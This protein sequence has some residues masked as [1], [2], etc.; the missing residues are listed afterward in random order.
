MLPDSSALP[1]VEAQLERILASTEFRK[2]MRMCRFLRLVT[3]EALLGKSDLCAGRRIRLC[4]RPQSRSCT[5]SGWRRFL[6]ALAKVPHRGG[7]RLLCRGLPPAARQTRP[8]RFVLVRCRAHRLLLW[9][10]DVSRKSGSSSRRAEPIWMDIALSFVHGGA[11]R[12]RRCASAV[13]WLEQP[14]RRHDPSAR[15]FARYSGEFDGMRST[16]KFAAVLAAMSKP[17]QRD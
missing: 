4:R 8:E 6:R 3:Q 1:P 7:T 14:D 10:A 2:S 13:H 9:R 11:T 17:R 15:I 5:L 16:P 12:T